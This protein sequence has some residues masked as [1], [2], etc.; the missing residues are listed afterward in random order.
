MFV[1]FSLFLCNILV[2]SLVIQFFSLCPIYSF[3]MFSFSLCFFLCVFP[4]IRYIFHPFSHIFYPFSHYSLYDIFFFS[5]YILAFFINSNKLTRLFVLFHGYFFFLDFSFFT[6]IYYAYFLFLLS[7]ALFLLLLLFR[8]SSYT[9][10]S[11]LLMRFFSLLFSVFYFA[12][13]TFITSTTVFI[14]IQYRSLTMYVCMYPFCPPVCLFIYQCSYISLHL[15]RCMSVHLP[16]Y[17]C[18]RSSMYICIFFICTSI[19]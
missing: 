9:F 5:I 17:L 15:Y 16:V 18:F 13:L 11:S 4:L 14:V 1:S 7:S 3:A 12:W 6:V 10:F 19:Y 8:F 2:F